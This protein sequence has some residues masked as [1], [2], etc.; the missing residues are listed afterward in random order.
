MPEA[1]PLVFMRASISS[2][3]SNRARDRIGGAGVVVA[4]VTEVVVAAVVVLAALAAEVVVAPVVVGVPWLPL[5]ARKKAAV[6]AAAPTATTTM[7]AATSWPFGRLG[8][9]VFAFWPCGPGYVGHCG[10]LVTIK[11]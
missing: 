6:A 11:E 4:V 7:L 9:G 10:G 5:G 1:I 2:G 8:A 3:A